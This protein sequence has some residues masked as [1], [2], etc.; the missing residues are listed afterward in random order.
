[1]SKAT[2]KAVAKKI[3]VWGAFAGV[4]LAMWR[5]ANGEPGRAA[6]E[7]SSGIAGATGVGMAGS[8][9]IDIG[10]FI[11]DIVYELENQGFIKN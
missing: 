1:M 6:A 8:L 4:G 2:A 3:P 7:L 9:A 5:L 11:A 10:I